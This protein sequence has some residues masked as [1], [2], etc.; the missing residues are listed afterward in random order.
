MSCSLNEK[1]IQLVES[2]RLKI[3]KVHEVLRRV[4]KEVDEGLLPSAQVAV[5]R[6]PANPFV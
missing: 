4:Q 1:Q 5:A 2:G 6:P 3:D